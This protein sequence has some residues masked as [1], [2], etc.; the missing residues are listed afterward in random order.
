MT[1][2]KRLLFLTYLGPVSRRLVSSKSSGNKSSCERRPFVLQIIMKQTLAHRNL[3][4]KPAVFLQ[5]EFVLYKNLFNCFA[6]NLTP[7][8]LLMLA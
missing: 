5:K 7:A 2:I 8:H 1:F 4:K 6:T 3:I